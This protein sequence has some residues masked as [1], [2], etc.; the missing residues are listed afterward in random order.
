MGVLLLTQPQS[1]ALFVPGLRARLPN[2]DIREDAAAIEP[3]AVEAIIAWQLKAETITGY[4]NLKLICAT[5]AGVEKVMP[6]PSVAGRVMVMRIVDPLV[7]I[8]VAQYVL[9]MALR[10]IRALPLYERQ[11]QDHEWIRHRPP[12]PYS[13]TAAVLGLGEAGRAVAALLQGAGFRMAGWSRTPRTMPGLECFSGEAGLAACLGRADVLVCSLPLTAE[14]AGLLN[15][16]TLSL[17]PKGAYVINVARGGHLVEA[18]LLESIDAGHV[19]GAALDVQAMEPLPEASPLWDHPRVTITPHIAAQAS[20]D[21][22]VTQFAENWRRFRAGAPLVN[23]ID[24]T[25]G[26]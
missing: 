22:V 3:Q 13:V 25:R 6:A 17:L 7:N 4:P 8:G 23:L 5:A 20:I 19:A 10:H 18:D 16:R 1:P 24:R 9:L 14:T 2:E 15:R 21:S 11:Q 12:E 26:Y